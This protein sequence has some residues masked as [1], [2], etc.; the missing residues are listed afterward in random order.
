M[1]DNKTDHF[2][3]L[4]EKFR[5]NN[6][7]TDEFQEFT[8]LLKAES[9]GENEALDLQARRDWQGSKA[10]LQN[11]RSHQKKARQRL[12][13]RRWVW[14]SAA[15][16]LLLCVALVFWPDPVQEDMVFRTGYGETRHI[17]LPDGS[18][19]LLNAN[20]SI[21]WSGDWKDRD[22][23]EVELDG[24]AFFD[25]A[26]KEGMHFEVSTPYVRVDVLGTE[27]NVKSRDGETGVFLQSGK[28]NL[29]VAG[30]VIRTIEMEPGD[31]VQY[32]DADKKLVAT[33][34][35]RIQERASWVDG[36][37]E[38]RNESV[39]EILNEFENLYGKS[40]QLDNTE[41]LEK[42][43]D[44]SLPYADWDLVRKALEIALDVEFSVSNDTIIVK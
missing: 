4:L 43:M 23:R 19:V 40:F 18:Q 41:L 44:L 8:A 3:N 31:F 33:E 20:S 39:P 10:I 36:M 17:E 6:L 11:I 1:S 13:W 32:D 25:V 37:L 2:N 42:R 9:L 14:S 21:T 22:F 26:H 27:F 28:V 30:E 7:T 34:Q 16:I 29:D 35:N 38:F 5:S 12:L 15:A 24:E